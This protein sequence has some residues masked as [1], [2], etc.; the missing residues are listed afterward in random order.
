MGPSQPSATYLIFEVARPVAPALSVCEDAS[1]TMSMRR[2]GHSKQAP[3][4][5]SVALQPDD[6]H[7]QQSPVGLVQVQWQA[8]AAHRLK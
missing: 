1:S 4:P 3:A 7:A 5:R 6:K 8:E 2:D